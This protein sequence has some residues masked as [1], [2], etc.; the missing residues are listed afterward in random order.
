MYYIYIYTYIY[1]YISSAAAVAVAVAVAAAAPLSRI[2]YYY[3]Y[4]EYLLVVLVYFL[5]LQVGSWCLYSS[6]A[7]CR[8]RLPCR[9][10]LLAAVSSC[11]F[12]SHGSL[13][14]LK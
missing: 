10:C 4:G 2:C 11:R 8:L 3:S 1:I 9:I 13:R 14:I 7:G 6:Y 12:P 5:S